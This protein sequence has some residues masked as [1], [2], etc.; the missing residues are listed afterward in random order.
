MATP[1]AMVEAVELALTMLRDRENDDRLWAREWMYNVDSDA[2]GDVTGLSSPISFQNACASRVNV[3]TIVA[4][5]DGII[6]HKAV[7][8]G[9]LCIPVWSMR[10]LTAGVIIE[11]FCGVEGFERIDSLPQPGA[12]NAIHGVGRFVQVRFQYLERLLLPRQKPWR[13]CLIGSW[14]QPASLELIST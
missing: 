2:V 14:Y 11:Q 10:G 13:K 1:P 5:P 3:S 6:S 9:S 4:K 12:E 8:A 7:E